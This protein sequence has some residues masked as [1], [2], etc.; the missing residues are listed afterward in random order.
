LPLFGQAIQVAG[1]LPVDRGDMSSAEELMASALEYLSAGERILSFPEGARSKTNDLT[2]FHSGPARMAIAAQVPIV[3]IGIAGAR[4]LI[5]RG[6]LR[7]GAAGE[8]VV[9]VGEPISTIGC[10]MKD[11]RKLTKELKRRVVKARALAFEK[12]AEAGRVSL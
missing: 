5:P 4:E 2:M 3:P 12:R 6:T 10:E 8:V 7:Y 11:A 1:Y 9:Q